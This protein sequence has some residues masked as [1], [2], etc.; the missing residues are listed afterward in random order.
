MGEKWLLGCEKTA[1]KFYV[2]YRFMALQRS[3]FLNNILFLRIS[4]VFG[5]P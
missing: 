2:L 3:T 1:S 5:F 4:F